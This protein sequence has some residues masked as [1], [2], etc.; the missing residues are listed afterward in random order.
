MKKVKKY[1]VIPSEA[2]LAGDCPIP[3]CITL[4]MYT[5]S[6]CS[7]FIPALDTA[8][9]IAIDPSLVAGNDE[10]DDIKEPIGVRAELTITTSLRTEVLE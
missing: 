9:E 8:A 10:R 2:C 7:G 6:T 5:S 4:P 1:G 3:A